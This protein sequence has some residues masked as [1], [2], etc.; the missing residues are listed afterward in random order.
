LSVNILLQ[1]LE[2]SPIKLNLFEV[3]GDDYEQLTKPMQFSYKDANGQ[4][5]GKP[6]FPSLQVSQNDF[7]NT[8][9]LFNFEKEHQIFDNNTFIEGYVIGAN[10]SVKLVLGYYQL[11]RSEALSGIV[12]ILVDLPKVKDM[13]NQEYEAMKRIRD[14]VFAPV[15]GETLKYVFKDPNT[16]EIVTTK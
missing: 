9:A 3:I 8:I 7:Q 14:F 12:P 5:M 10:S 4:Q 15:E 1:Q 16:K 6:Y 2:F 11:S 13:E